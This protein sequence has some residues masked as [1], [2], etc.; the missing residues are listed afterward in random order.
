MF[1]G[2]YNCNRII[3]LNIAV[4]DARGRLEA[5]VSVGHNHFLGNYE[6]CK[7]IKATGEIV[8]LLDDPEDAKGSATHQFEANYCRVYHKSNISMVSS[9][10]L[11]ISF[12]SIA[13]QKNRWLLNYHSTIQLR[14]GLIDSDQIGFMFNSGTFPDLS[15]HPIDSNICMSHQQHDI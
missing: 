10:T 12:P 9:G 1:T 3:V 11:Y 15:I 6:L 2:S 4:A 7:S 5:G 14:Y 13:H 8:S